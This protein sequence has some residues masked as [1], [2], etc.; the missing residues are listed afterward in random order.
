[1]PNTLSPN[2]SLILPTVGQEP[3]PNWALDL[4]NS[5]SLVDQHN[6][7]PGS[8]VQITPAGMDINIDLP[9]GG[10]SAINLKSV[11]FSSQLSPL[12]SGSDI[13]CL[14]VSGQNLY[15]NDTLG[16]QVQITAAG[17]VNGTPGSIGNLIAPAAVNYVPANQTFVFQSNQGN[18]TPA[19]LDAGNLYLRNI[20][21]GGN[22]IQ[23]QPNSVLPASYSL[24]LPSALPAATSVLLL[25]NLGNV[26][27]SGTAS[28]LSVTTLNSS[29]ANA[30]VG[31]TIKNDAGLLQFKNTA[32]NVQFAAIIGS[33]SGLTLNLPDTADSYVFQVN[34]V[35]K[36]A[37]NNTGIDYATFPVK[38]TDTATSTINWT[39][40]GNYN[41][42]TAWQTIATVGS[43]TI[44][45]TRS[46]LFTTNRA[47]WTAVIA[48]STGA[49]TLYLRYKLVGPSNYY[50]FY[51]RTSDNEYIN[52]AVTPGVTV[53]PAYT[54][55][56]LL[57]AGT[58]TWY[59]EATTSVNSIV[60]FAGIASSNPGLAVTATVLY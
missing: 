36:A 52:L 17:A 21:P 20:V 13:G 31:I 32:D 23:L 22:Y 16:N 43:F 47:D 11:R 12:S 19:S 30:S 7:S 4:N 24:I 15:F 50:P 29:T 1:M 45:K 34:G 53:L 48:T 3:G 58:Y 2:M 14:Y 35:P 55:V 10:N 46:V 37:I 18:N 41:L 44:S 9:F 25:D 56:L 28:S 49:L 5:L 40:A 27:T 59:V 39:S 26:A 38:E 57:P 60:N 54:D 6:H 51:G 8:G 42:T 33:S